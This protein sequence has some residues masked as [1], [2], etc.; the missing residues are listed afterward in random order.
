VST[1]WVVA[2]PDSPGAPELLDFLRRNDA[3]Y[4]WVDPDNDALIAYLGARDELRG[5]SMPLVVCSDGRTIEPPARYQD[6][7]PDLDDERAQRYVETARWRSAVADAFGLPTRPL[8]DD[9]DVLIVGAGPAGLTAAVYAA[10]EGLR[11][12]VVERMAPGGQAGTSARIENYPGFPQGVAGADLAAG[13]YEQALR[14]GAEVL[15]GVEILR[16]TPRQGTEQAHVELSSGTSIRNSCGVIATG[17]AY[18]RLEAAGVEELVGRGV[19]Y[20]SAPF[21]APRYAGCDVAI[22]GAANSAG[23]A[24]VDLAGHARTVTIVCRAR[25][26]GVAMS[27]YLVERIEAT[28]NI[29][30]LTETSVVA[31]AGTERLEAVT[32]EGRGRTEELPVQGLFVL[33]GGQPLTGGV[34]GWLRRNEHGF[35]VTGPDLLRDGDRRWWPLERDPFLLESS[36]PGLFVAGDVR[37]G[38]SK[39]VASA[40]GEGALA[41]QLVHRYLADPEGAGR[42][43]AGGR[44][45]AVVPGMRPRP[46]SDD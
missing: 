6:Q 4:R 29:R 27:R 7:R 1:P 30:V 20:G 46:E 25:A 9:Y 34:S 38:S 26:L 5:R 42:A 16:V 36:Q 23:Q 22:V 28:P 37:H 18:R 3:D 31:A 40:V 8:R 12:L 21:E 13:A 41:I 39:R 43:P 11:A 24:A 14:F 33:I 45:R 35:L 19:H 32:V 44:E 17:V 15:V 2:R 10:S